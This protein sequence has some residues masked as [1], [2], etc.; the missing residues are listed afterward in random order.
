ME[1]SIEKIGYTRKWDVKAETQVRKCG[2]S[3]NGGYIVYVEGYGGGNIGYILNE[4]K[5]EI[6]RELIGHTKKVI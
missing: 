1:N 6:H 4:R 3:G 2:V 5:G